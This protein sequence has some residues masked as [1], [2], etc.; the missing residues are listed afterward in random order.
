MKA[1]IPIAGL[2]SRL[3]PATRVLPKPFFPLVDPRDGLAKPAIHLIVDEALRYI[4]LHLCASLYFLILLTGQVS[5][6][7]VLF[8][9]L[10]NIRWCMTTSLIQ[11]HLRVGN[12]WLNCRKLYLFSFLFYLSFFV[13]FYNLL[14]FLAFLFL[15]GCN[16]NKWQVSSQ[17]QY[18]MNHWASVMPSSVPASMTYHKR[19]LVKQKNRRKREGRGDR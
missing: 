4:L 9:I 15:D 7:F 10:A 16:R 5:A 8:C 12:R 19:D 17:L 1:V 13:F 18:K 6:K 2:G 11:V 14:L 3:F